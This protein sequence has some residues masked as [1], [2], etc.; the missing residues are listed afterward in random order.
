MHLSGELFNTMAKTKMQH[1]P[2]KGSAP[3][4]TDVM[5]GQAD[6]AFDSIVIAKPLIESGKLRAI[7]VTSKERSPALPDV[8]AIDETVPGYSMTSW[9]GVLAPA[10]TPKPVVERLQREIAKALKAPEVTERLQS[11]AAQPVG[12]TPEEFTKFI[13]SETA[14]WAPVVKE[15]GAIVG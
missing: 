9:I 2:Y 14:K 5:G 13:K 6:L 10:H 8:P 3:A 12:S 1:I 15:T 4:L 11:L 7:G